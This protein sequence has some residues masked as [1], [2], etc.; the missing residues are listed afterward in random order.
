MR[1]DKLLSDL[2]YGTRKEIKAFI[3]QGLVLVND[4]VINDASLHVDPNKDHIIFD[5][6]HVVYKEQLVLMMHKPSGYLSAN[7]DLHDQTVFDLLEASYKRYDLNIAG[8]LDKDAEGLLILTNDGSLIHQIIHPKK[9]IYKTYEV[10]T[11]A[12][13]DNIEDLL[14]PMTLLDGNNQPYRVSKPI[15]INTNS[16]HAVIK[17]SEGKF[18]Q[19]KRMFNAIGHEVIKLKR[20]AINELELDETLEEGSVRELNQQEIELLIKK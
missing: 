6:E 17:I 14:K 9:E 3:K 15:L 8:R 7:Y 16:N 19:V 11:K 4:T 18:H 12:P 10:I 5:Q 1:I 2:K 20:L 13:I